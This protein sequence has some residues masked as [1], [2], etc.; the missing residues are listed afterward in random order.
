M[1]SL[2]C[3]SPIVAAY[4]AQPWTG[5]PWWRAIPLG[6]VERVLTFSEVVVVLVLAGWALRAT[7][8]PDRARPLRR[9]RAEV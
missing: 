3:F 6:A 8:A 7:R 9:G 4:A 1:W 5:V 2:L